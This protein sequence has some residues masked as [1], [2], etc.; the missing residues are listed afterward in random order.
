MLIQAAITELAVKAFHKGIL[1]RLAWLNKV[2]L[3]TRYAW[4]EKGRL[5]GKLGTVIADNGLRQ[6]SGQCQFIQI[7]AQPGSR[8]RVIDE[9]TDT[10][11]WVII[12]DIEHPKASAIGQ[13]VADK[14]HRPPLVSLIWDHH[15]NPGAHQLLASLG[16]NLQ[17]FFGVESVGVLLV[18]HQSFALE[19]AMEQQ[20][21]VTGILLGQ[22]LQT[23][24]QGKIIHTTRLVT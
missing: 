8:D 20:I 11:T 18:N 21:A 24:A 5:T 15:G 2:Q 1:G 12:H 17:A 16:A 7:T 6:R 9:L 4:P 3:H 14:V 19:H 22:C 23:W 13:L 10:F